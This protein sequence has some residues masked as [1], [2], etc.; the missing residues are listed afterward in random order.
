MDRGR[1]T[2]AAKFKQ[3]GDQPAAHSVGAGRR[4]DQEPLAGRWVKWH[5]DLELGT[6]PATGPL[7]GLGPAAVENVF[8]PRVRLQIAGHRAD[9]GAVRSLG[10]Q[11]LTLPHGT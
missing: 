3:A 4:A 8:A 5:G 11:M 9:E 2:L 6:A 1:L 10:Q 7:V